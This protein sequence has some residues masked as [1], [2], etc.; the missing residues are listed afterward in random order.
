MKTLLRILKESIPVVTRVVARTGTGDALKV[1]TSLKRLDDAGGQLGLHEATAVAKALS[2]VALCESLEETEKDSIARLLEDTLGLIE[3][4]EYPETESWDEAVTGPVEIQ[5]AVL[6][7]SDESEGMEWRVRVIESGVTVDKR[8]LYTED[9][10]R[11]AVELFEGAQCFADHA[12]EGQTPSVGKLV[13]RFTN[14]ELVETEQGTVAIDAD[15][16]VFESSSY[17]GMLREIYQAE[18]LDT[19]GFSINGSGK[20]RLEH[21]PNGTIR[22]VETIDGIGSVDLVTKPNAGGKL[23]ELRAAVYEA[24]DLVRKPEVKKNV[25]EP[26]PEPV[27]ESVKP[28]IDEVQKLKEEMRSEK[29]QNGKEKLRASYSLPDVAMNAVEGRFARAE[30]LDEAESVLMEAQTIWASAIEEQASSTPTYRQ[31]DRPSRDVL[32]VQGMLAGEA[33]DG[34]KPFTSL[35][36]AYSSVAGKNTWQLS[37]GS[38]ANEVLRASHGF[39]S[40]RL[41]ETVKTSD[42]TYTLGQGLYREMIR[43][44]N[45]PGFDD[46]RK[47]V[48]QVSNLNDM[49]RRDRL[50]LDYYEVL[51]EVDEDGTYPNLTDPDETRAYYTPTKRG[52]LASFTWEDVL[53]DDLGALQQIPKKLAMS[54]KVT[55][56]YNLMNIFAAA[57]PPTCSYD[58]VALFHSTSH[59]AN[60]DTN[61]LSAANFATGRKV[62]MT[63]TV[64]GNDY[65]ALGLPPKYMLIPP[66]LEGTARKLRDSDVDIDTSGENVAN[67]WKG[68]FDIIVIPFWSD[69][70]AWA[71]VAD[72][73]MVP[74]IEV[75]FLGGKEE[76]DL[77][78][79]AANSGSNFTADKVTYKVRQVWG[80]CIL[81]HRGMYKS[82][83][84]G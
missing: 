45:L 70:D 52:G 63:Q 49:R 69:T 65:M 35:R 44:Y 84:S 76:P 42:W 6:R 54:A 64:S 51:S 16:R 9:A 14:P 38:F 81:D 21:K 74:T 36:E 19:V 50:R 73:K 30:S 43:Q 39:D 7:A 26:S 57:T 77:F 66:D 46:W 25:S 34:V 47:V 78:T 82:N 83:G 22:V 79:E 48:S 28:L 41:V 3:G 31:I 67:P 60:L 53:N 75:G 8:H 1:L 27:K 68:T 18:A 59:G 33:I 80:Y 72:P 12:P 13:G 15:L 37:P 40:E 29:L 32:R 56:W 58:S 11:K 2:A 71:L 23:L 17:A 61:D 20:V 5:A 4:R 55:I 10:L 62:I 24:A